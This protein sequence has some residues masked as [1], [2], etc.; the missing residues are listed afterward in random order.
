MLVTLWHL[1]APHLPHLP[2]TF[3]CSFRLT[4]PPKL[5]P[6]VLS[7]S[8]QSVAPDNDSRNKHLS[9]AN[10]ADDVSSG[11][12]LGRYTDA[13]AVLSR[14]FS[15]ASSATFSPDGSCLAVVHHHGI[16]TFLRLSCRDSQ[17]MLVPRA[18]GRTAVLTLS[19]S[20]EHQCVEQ[21]QQQQDR[22]G[23]TGRDI[24]QGGGASKSPSSQVSSGQALSSSGSS[25]SEAADEGLAVRWTQ[26][27][28][29]GRQEGVFAVCW[30]SNNIAFVSHLSGR[31]T[32]LHWPDLTVLSGP[33]PILCGPSPLLVS[34]AACQA[35]N[36][37]APSSLAYAS[38]LNPRINDD[39][40]HGGAG[41]AAAAAAPAVLVFEPVAL[42]ATTTGRNP[43]SNST[44]LPGSAPST[45]GAEA[46]TFFSSSSSAPGNALRLSSFVERSPEYMLRSFTA[47]GLIGNALAVAQAAGLST[48]RVYKGAWKAL[49][50]A[51]GLPRDRLT[52]GLVCSGKGEE[53]AKAGSKRGSLLANGGYDGNHGRGLL[54]SGSEA[55]GGRAASEEEGEMEGRGVTQYLALV[56]DREW[57]V[58]EC[59]SVVCG[60]AQGMAAL[61]DL[62]LNCTAAMYQAQLQ[63]QA[64]PSRE[65]IR[66]SRVALLFLRDRL[67]TYLAMNMGR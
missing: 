63:G 29:R 18:G 2:P 32:A 16:L 60:S 36:R 35:V 47:R 46:V 24:A 56:S 19:S 23:K 33:M 4:P 42:Q 7:R 34:A 41:T 13:V 62:G 38:T 61:L 57:V 26:C 40:R 43:G 9:D 50:A 44:P 12:G 8:A 66:E 53:M 11:H 17:L 54:W 3:L 25:G 37:V 58:G 27:R 48:D 67:Q 55:G 52:G 1:P 15:A 22:T 10:D 5:V 28:A 14:A 31:V 51:L 39:A 64:Q 30:A 49:A 6:Y 59:V 21:Q 45:G 20:D 65:A